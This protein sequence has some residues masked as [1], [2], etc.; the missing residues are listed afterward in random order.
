MYGHKR[1][2]QQ[3]LVRNI[4]CIFKLFSVKSQIIN[5][6][7]WKKFIVMYQEITKKQLFSIKK[8]NRSSPELGKSKYYSISLTTFF[9]SA[10]TSSITLYK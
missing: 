3:P 4:L 10:Q 9:A 1:R 5:H 8:N 7:Y 6:T 2:K